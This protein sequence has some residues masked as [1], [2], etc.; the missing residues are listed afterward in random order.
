MLPRLQRAAEARVRAFAHIDWF[1]LTSALAIS[2]LG[3]ATMRS[4]SSENAYFDKQIVWIGLALIVFFIA[5]VPE[6]G[7]LRRTPVVAGL[8]VAVASLLA[9][10]FILGSVVRGAQNR[11][12]LGFFFVQPADPA[13]LILVAVLS[14]YFTRRHIEIKHIRHIL[15]SGAYAFVLFVLVFFQPDFGS[16]IIIFSIWLG[17]VLVAGISWKHLA[18]LFAV[19]AIA[20]GGVWH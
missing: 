6:Y 3:L 1:L 14:K 15:V 18:V 16:A 9:F 8:Y 11:F 4:F 20:V 19:A 17:M 5:S 13:K 2:F 7:F 10:I 12:N